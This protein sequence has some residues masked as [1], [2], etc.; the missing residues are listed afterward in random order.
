MKTVQINY[1]QARPWKW[2]ANKTVS[3][4]VDGQHIGT[5]WGLSKDTILA[6]VRKMLK[7]TR[8]KST[9]TYG[10]TNET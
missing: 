2:N 10:G 8:V 1:K 6:I 3:V 9:V 7:V 5:F 4:S